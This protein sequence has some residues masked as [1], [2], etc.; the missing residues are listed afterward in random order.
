LWYE[1]ELQAYI[2]EWSI[3]HYCP[4]AYD[5]FIRYHLCLFL[6]NMRLLGK[7]AT[8]GIYYMIWSIW[9][10]DGE[11]LHTTSQIVAMY[12]TSNLKL[13]SQWVNSFVM[14]MTQSLVHKVI[15]Q[16][17]CGGKISEFKKLRCPFITSTSNLMQQKVERNF[18]SRL[19]SHGSRKSPSW[20]VGVVRSATSS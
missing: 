11:Y 17:F 1:A 2:Y 20:N 6:H 4:H 7:L 19:A 18:F 12:R 10:G 14:I 16:V 15:K 9:N 5:W 13:I 8:S 3:P